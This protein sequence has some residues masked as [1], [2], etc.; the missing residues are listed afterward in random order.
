[1]GRPKR[2][3][4]E[5]VLH[6]SLQECRRKILQLEAMQKQVDDMVI[7]EKRQFERLH[8][9]LKKSQ[10]DAAYRRS[11]QKIVESLEK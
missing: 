1:L 11:L 2:S 3:A 8:F 4:G 9:A 10:D 7:R 6:T 5:E